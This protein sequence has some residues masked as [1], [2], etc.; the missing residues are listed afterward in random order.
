MLKLN[1]VSATELKG[2][3]I[4]AT[5]YGWGKSRPISQHRPNLSFNPFSQVGE[6][7]EIQD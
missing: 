2:F 3:A 7:S 5:E 6:L 4:G 1:L